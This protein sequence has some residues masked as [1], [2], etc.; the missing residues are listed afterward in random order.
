MKIS[1][2]TYN[3]ILKDYTA[4]G[5]NYQI[6]L[7]LMQ[8]KLILMNYSKHTIKTYLFMF[9]NFLGYLHPLP[10]HQ[11]TK[12]QVIN[13]HLWLV[14]ERKV[15]ISYQNQSINAIKFYLEKVLKHPVEVYDLQRPLKQKTLPKVLSLAE[16][17]KIIEATNNLKHRT[18]LSVIY[19]SGLRISECIHLKICDI[20]GE[21]KRIWVRNAK[22]KKD[23]ITLLS[24]GLLQ[25]LRDYYRAYRP[26][27]WLFE[28]PKAHQYSAS[29]IRHIFN[30]AKQKALVT[31][32]ATVHTLRH[33]FATH[34]LENGTNLRYIQKLLGHNSSKT[35]EIYTHVCN[36]NLTN[37]V[38]PFDLLDK[39]DTF[40]K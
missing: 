15:S 1:L 3:S 8:Q 31:A 7:Q 14:T 36:T 21:H 5:Q 30:R 26:K 22:G 40:G 39:K 29:S 2:T 23:R 34:L 20:D 4:L 12:A 10:L 19:G 28:G 9:K 37:I 16:V 13:Y 27:I 6:S 18:I 33:S 25:L 38:S 11:V 35:T 24:H 32:P 17:S